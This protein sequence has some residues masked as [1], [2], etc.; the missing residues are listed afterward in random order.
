MSSARI[1]YPKA[2]QKDRRN[3]YELI[4]LNREVIRRIRE[5]LYDEG[6][7][8]RT[9][10]ALKANVQYNRLSKYV[11]WL[12]SIGAIQLIS[13]GKSTDILITEKGKEILV[14]F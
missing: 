5:V 9:R 14:Y 11:R 12:E 4:K 13:D 7:M 8:K 3:N 10:L 6:R 2:R 1:V